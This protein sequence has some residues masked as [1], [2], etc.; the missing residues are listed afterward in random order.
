MKNKDAKNEFTSLEDINSALKDD[1]IE[2][3]R[4]FYKIE[5]F[6]EPRRLFRK[7]KTATVAYSTP[8]KEVRLRGARFVDK[9]PDGKVVE[10]TD[11]KAI[12]PLGYRVVYLF[13]EE[14]DISVL[15]VSDAEE[16]GEDSL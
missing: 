14:N 1:D 6:T 11:V 12:Y 4:Y 15:S 7:R 3:R 5:I 8:S 9:R 16:P 2:K 13:K 10:I